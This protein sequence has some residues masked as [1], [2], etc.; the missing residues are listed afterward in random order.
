[1]R[2]S[3]VGALYGSRQFP[4]SRFWNVP[5]GNL[6]GV[7]AP[8]LPGD[9]SA[10]GDRPATRD[11][12]ALSPLMA[13][14]LGPAV[15]GACALVESASRTLDSEY[16][17][18]GHH[19]LNLVRAGHLRCYEMGRECYDGDTQGGSRGSTWARGRQTT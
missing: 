1:V 8:H 2:K 3:E 13:K 16:R 9:A 10:S 4:P 7:D 5:T 6:R 18:A 17:S 14:G 15:P 12:I 19:R 11:G